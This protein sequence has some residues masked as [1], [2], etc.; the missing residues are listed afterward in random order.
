MCA[1]RFSGETIV[2]SCLT[3]VWPGSVSSQLPPR[4]AGEVDDHAAG[5]HALDGL[6]GDELRRRAARDERRRDDDVE[7][8]DRVGQRLLLLRRAPRRSARARSRPRPA[9]SSPRSR[10]FAPSD[11]TCSATSGAHVVAGR[12]GAEAARRRERL[13]AGDAGAEH[14]HL[15]GRD[16]AG[17]G[18]QHREEAAEV[19]GAR[20]A[21]AS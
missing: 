5:L 13:Q 9:A 14:E 8:L 10:N 20:R 1:G 2:T 12:H 21:T 15:R 17:G 7:A 16:R 6:G 18:H 4:L 19:L 11:S 3:T